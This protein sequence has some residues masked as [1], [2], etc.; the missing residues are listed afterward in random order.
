M[1]NNQVHSD[2]LV[3]ET[4]GSLGIFTVDPSIM[5]TAPSTATNLPNQ[6]DCL[7]D[8]ESHRQ[9]VKN[10]DRPQSHQ[11]RQSQVQ[12]E[13]PHWSS[14]GASRQRVTKF[15]GTLNKERPG[16]TMA[17]SRLEDAARKGRKNTR[18]V[19][20]VKSAV[21]HFVD[22][23]PSPTAPATTVLAVNNTN[24]DSCIMCWSS[25]APRMNNMIGRYNPNR[26]PLR[27]R[28]CMTGTPNR[29]C[30][31]DGWSNWVKVKPR[32]CSFGKF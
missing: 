14:E 32:Y 31:E 15:S 16:K 18:K 7:T 4:I 24:E 25:F 6:S 5:E 21:N 3:G 28:R 22:E 10:Q 26:I 1:A 20:T 27:N 29:N 12:K 13:P 23:P 8:V 11:L 17:Q 9:L 2:E 30:C 19:S